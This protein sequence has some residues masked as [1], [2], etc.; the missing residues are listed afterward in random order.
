MDVIGKENLEPL[1][2][3]KPQQDVVADEKPHGADDETLQKPD[4]LPTQQHTP[5]PVVVPTEE[6]PAT[7]E[8]PVTTTNGVA[9]E[10]PHNADGSTAVEA[11][12]VDYVVEKILDDCV[13]I[14]GKKQYLLK[15]KGQNM[16]M[17]RV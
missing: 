6:K 1:S 2:A 13:D 10:A 12:E 9:P 16:N 14:H 17:I 4:A 7:G 8:I 3:V 5:Q 15:W 11:V